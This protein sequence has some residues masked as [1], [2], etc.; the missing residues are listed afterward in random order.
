MLKNICFSISILI[1]TFGIFGFNSNE[2][3]VNN[4]KLK[5]V[6]NKYYSLDEY[7][8]AKGFIIVFICNKCPMVKLYSERLKDLQSKYQYKNVYL[9]AINSMDTLAYAEESFKLMRKESKKENFNFPYLQ[10][11]KQKIAKQF[12]ASHTPQ[13]FVIWKNESG[14]YLI[15]YKGAIDDNAGDIKTAKPFL[16]NAIDELLNNENVTL[17]NTDSFGCRIF[18]RGEKAKMD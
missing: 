8:N 12:N 7:K 1:I 14:Q 15:K 6:D 11:K 5:G 3:E 17:P 18:Y 9:L 10:D 4:F 13:A 2:T 16:S